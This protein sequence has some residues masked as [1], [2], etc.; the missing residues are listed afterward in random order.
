[1][2]IHARAFV[3]LLQETA[4][5]GMNGNDTEADATKL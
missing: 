3:L 1:M 2:V 4:F 5:V